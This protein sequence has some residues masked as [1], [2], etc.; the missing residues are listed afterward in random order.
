VSDLFCTKCGSAITKHAC[1]NPECSGKL[2]VAES[3]RVTTK[4]GAIK[5]GKEKPDYSLLPWEGIKEAAMIM[6]KN[7]DIN[8]GKYPRDN[9]KGFLGEI[10]KFYT[11]PVL[12][13]A[14]EYAMGI[15][16]DKD[17][18]FHPLAHVICDCLFIIWEEEEMK[19][20]K[21]E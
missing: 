4:T 7:L 13:H 6:T 21:N 12:G 1:S 5:Y 8:G 17:D 18:G 15:R 14:I 2:P 16:K 20:R 10:S 11:R 19:R 3:N 9:W